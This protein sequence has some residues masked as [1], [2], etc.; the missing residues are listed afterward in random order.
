M[1]SEGMQSPESNIPDDIE[2]QR[3]AAN[4]TVRVKNDTVV[5]N[6]FPYVCLHAAQLCC[7]SA[8]MKKMVPSDN[9]EGIVHVIVLYYLCSYVDS[10]FENRV[11]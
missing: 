11:S 6:I 4:F 7:K 10:F 9:T 3:L 5:Q 8:F 1:S 2:M